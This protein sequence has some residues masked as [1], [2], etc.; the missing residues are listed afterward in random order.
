MIF[1]PPTKEL[2]N[3]EW[4]VVRLKEDGTLVSVEPRDF[5]K[6][7]HLKLEEVQKPVEGDPA[8]LRFAELKEKKW[9]NLDASE[10]GEYTILKDKYDH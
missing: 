2:H 6:K 8:A 9:A 5:N 1:D 3:R 10:R 7:V 4:I